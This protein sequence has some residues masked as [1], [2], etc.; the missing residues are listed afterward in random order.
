LHDYGEYVLF[1]KTYGK[2]LKKKIDFIKIPKT[3]KGWNTC[4]DWLL[5]FWAR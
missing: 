3:R 1:E 5:V 4:L 2:T